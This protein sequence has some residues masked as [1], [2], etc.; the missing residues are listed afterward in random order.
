[1][2]TQPNIFKTVALNTIFIYFG[3]L[4]NGGLWLS[5]FILHWLMLCSMMQNDS[6]DMTVE[7][8]FAFEWFGVPT[9]ALMSLASLQY[10]FWNIGTYYIL[11]RT[12]KTS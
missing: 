7:S 5:Q 6:I 12:R 10:L 3:L 1:V 11:V 8:Y 2:L 9:H 4:S